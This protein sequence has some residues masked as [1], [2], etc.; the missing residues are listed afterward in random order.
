MTPL[1]EAHCANHPAV[2]AVEICARCG[3]FLC[4]DCVEYFRDETPVCST[5]LPLMAPK[6]ASLRSKLAPVVS[7][8]GLVAMVS[9]FLFPGRP[10]LA[11]WLGGMIFTFTGLTLAMLELRQK[12]SPSGRKWAIAGLILSVLGALIIA[13]LVFGFTRFIRAQ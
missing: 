10:G 9:G 5:C 6:P 11:V 13:G 12:A 2:G 4:G 3:S 8:I 7:S 1:A